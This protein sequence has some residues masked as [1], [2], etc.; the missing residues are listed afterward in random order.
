MVTMLDTKEALNRDLRQKRFTWE[1]V[2]AHPHSV[3]T[4]GPTVRA[5]PS[6]P[7][8]GA[9]WGP[10]NRNCVWK[11]AP[12]AGNGYFCHQLE[13]KMIRK[14]KCHCGSKGRRGRGSHCLQGISAPAP[15][16]GPFEHD[17]INSKYPGSRT[18]L[19]KLEPGSF[20]DWLCDL[21]LGT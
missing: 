5:H 20:I 15:V 17:F 4:P 14:V 10:V 11:W 12:P 3:S 7:A 19:P 13:N 8:K 2:L 16:L 21:R 18:N 1:N 6:G 9:P